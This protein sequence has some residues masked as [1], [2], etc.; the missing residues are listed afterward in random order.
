ME[1]SILKDSIS[2]SDRC[3][4]PVLIKSLIVSRESSSLGTLKLSMIDVF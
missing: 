3:S 2:E 1:S 4:S